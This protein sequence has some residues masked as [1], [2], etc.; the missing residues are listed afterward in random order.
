M[1]DT[2]PVASRTLASLDCHLKTKVML[3]VLDED[4][5]EVRRKNSCYFF[6]IYFSLAYLLFLRVAP[7]I[8]AHGGL[9]L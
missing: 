6:I 9:G 4:F 8:N 3:M 7:E 2:Y 1:P 5:P